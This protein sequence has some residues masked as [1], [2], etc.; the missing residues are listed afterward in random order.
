M[1]DHVFPHIG[2]RTVD[3]VTSADVMDTLSP[4]WNT[5]HV[6]A[7]KVRQRIGMVMRWAIAQGYRQ[8][9]PAG[10][11]ITAA[12]PKRP[13]LVEHRAALPHPEVAAALAAVRN[14]DAWIGTRLAFEF[15]VLTAARSAEVRLARWSEIDLPRMAWTVP[16]RRM[17]A[18]REHRVPL[19]GRAVELLRRAERLG[20]DAPAG[21][22]PG[23]HDRPR[24]GHRRRDPLEARPRPGPGGGAAWLPVVVPRLGVG[25]DGP[26]RGRS[27]RRPWPTR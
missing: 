7:K 19:C 20:L 23:V 18:G 14:A 17:K 2:G 9:N 10:D 25:A 12:M 26:P 21:D 4:I 27:S 3:E 11:A 1:R 24:E 5:R 8:D 13:T 6:T 15:L 22:G 16:G